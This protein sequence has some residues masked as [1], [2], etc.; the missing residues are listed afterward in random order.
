MR[1][2]SSRVP[3]FSKL[4][5]QVKYGKAKNMK[6]NMQ[7]NVPI[8]IAQLM[9]TLLR[10]SVYMIGLKTACLATLCFCAFILCGIFWLPAKFSGLMGKIAKNLIFY[11]FK[12][13]HDP[14]VV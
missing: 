2:F 8:S 1:F 11:S 4:L 9:E 14:I 10:S 6:T 13:S 12:I 5:V 7:M 3:L